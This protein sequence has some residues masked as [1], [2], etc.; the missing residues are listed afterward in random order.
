M[1]A[2]LPLKGEV[3]AWD[4]AAR[5]AW[6]A[7][8][9][10]PAK[11]R[12]AGTSMLHELLK[13][14]Q[15]SDSGDMPPALVARFNHARWVR[16]LSPDEFTATGLTPEEFRALGEI[17]LLQ[18]T[19]LNRR[20]PQDDLAEAFRILG[21]IYRASPQDLQAYPVLAVAFA[22]VFDKPFPENWPHSQVRKLP[23]KEEAGTPA[24]RFAYYAELDKKRQLDFSPAELSFTELK[25]V[26]N[27][28]VP[29]S[30][31][32]WARN[33]VRANLGSFER[34]FNMIRYD[35]NRLLSRN[36][37]WPAFQPYTLAKIQEIGGICVDQAY[38]G[39]MVGKA[40]GI[41]TLFFVGQGSG[42][43]H[44][45]YGY[46]KRNHSWD[47]NVGRYESQNYP[48]GEAR[49]PQNWTAVKD[50]ELRQFTE[51]VEQNPRFKS[52]ENLMFWSRTFASDASFKSN[53]ELLR[54]VMPDWIEIWRLQASW[55]SAN[56][57]PLEVQKEFYRQ[58]SLQFAKFPDL[59]VEGQSFYYAALMELGET[60]A[61]EQ[62]KTEVVRQ[63]RRK[64]FDI[65][66]DAAGMQ[67]FDLLDKKDWDGAEKEYK[68]V[69]RQFDNKGGGNL[70]YGV[71][72]PFVETLV[73][74]GQFKLAEN[75]LE[76]AIK[77][78]PQ[79]YGSILTGEF[80]EL[81]EKIRKAQSK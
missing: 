30:E 23:W 9:N 10:S 4:A 32:D 11:W 44:A 21:Q 46:L 20:V 67:I 25:Y 69:V 37:D 16:L 39:A 33:Q 74:E 59:R 34:V 29:T 31:L 48:V 1:L 27:S 6:W 47:M 45:W 73:E 2:V 40:R 71:V 77:K 49:D 64:R 72:Q 57:Q 66:I 76:F 52:A 78:M 63:N 50:E 8:N 38:F 41:P 35:E 36:Y 61:A 56:K 62:V 65:G 17:E 42:G 14:F 53:L 51:V 19:L 79:G 24:Q 58:W 13:E 18:R 81:Q 80:E 5:D 12:D 55:L 60:A 7:E 43:G 15:V 54:R 70:F 75:S 26:V 3:P 68:R 22:L 28:L